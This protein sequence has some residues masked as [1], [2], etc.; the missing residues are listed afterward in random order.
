MGNKTTSHRKV[1][2]TYTQNAAGIKTVYKSY[3]TLNNGRVASDNP[4]WK[5]LVKRGANATNSLS[6]FSNSQSFTPSF[7]AAKVTTG[8]D[9]GKVL[10]T[11]T[12]HPLPAT[13]VTVDSAKLQLASTTAATRLIKKI[14]A[15]TKSF[16]GATFLGELR[17]SA[18]MIRHPAEALAGQLQKHA[19]KLKRLRPKHPNKQWAKTVS[20]SWLEGCFGWAPLLSDISAIAE[21]SLRKFNEDRIKRLSGTGEES[22][23]LS[24]KLRRTGGIAAIY[25]NYGHEQT[26]ERKVI[27][28]AGLKTV[29]DRD[30]SGLERVIAGSEIGSWRDLVPTAWELIP[31]SF[32]IDYFGNVGDVINVACV[33]LNN[34]AWSSRT[35]ITMNKRVYLGLS[36]EFTSPT[37]AESQSSSGYSVAKHKIV[38][39]VI[40]PIP[41]PELRF[42]L[43]RGNLQLANIAALLG[44]RLKLTS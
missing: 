36:H 27:Y 11:S 39:R 25:Y 4:H 18:R 3:V 14:Q 41:I 38:D 1:F 13:P 16:S 2:E 20:D 23:S 15:E 34:V 43:P 10:M 12:A 40:A 30:N 31:W 5:S 42:E 21:S 6:A 17:E 19:D 8:V 22:S 26:S 9:A 24:Q 28:T 29:V 7:A 35:T 32:L 44:S 37:Y 33:S